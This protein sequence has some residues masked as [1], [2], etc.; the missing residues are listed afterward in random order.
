MAARTLRARARARFTAALSH[1][2]VGALSATHSG[3]KSGR[4]NGMRRVAAARCARIVRRMRAPGRLVAHFTSAPKS[5]QSCAASASGNWMKLRAIMA[6]WLLKWIP[7]AVGPSLPSQGEGRGG[8]GSSYT[9]RKG[10]ESPALRN[11]RHPRCGPHAPAGRNG[12]VFAGPGRTA[13]SMQAPRKAL[14]RSGRATKRS[15]WRVKCG[16]AGLAA[17]WSLGPVFGVC[18]PSA[19]KRPGTAP[20]RVTPGRAKRGPK[21]LL[22]HFGT[23]HAQRV[24]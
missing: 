10:R 17:R 18:V 9:T 3:G 24:M 8:V 1:C 22:E 20:A 16:G 7:S 5:R 23:S 12:G 11:K 6:V 19:L 2:G 14:E 21:F 13:F 15:D 4:T